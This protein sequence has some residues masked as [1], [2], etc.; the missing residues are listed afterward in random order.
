MQLRSIWN[1]FTPS[2][3]QMNTA[4]QAQNWN[5]QAKHDNPRKYKAA[6]NAA[7]EVNRSLGN[8]PSG[9][10]TDSNNRW[11]APLNAKQMALIKH[12][13]LENVNRPGINYNR[14]TKK[15]R[16]LEAILATPNVE[17]PSNNGLSLADR[18]EM[19]NRNIPVIT[20]ADLNYIGGQM[21]EFIGHGGMG[22][23]GGGF[24]GGK[25]AGRT[26]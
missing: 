19:I 9:D 20:N 6:Q 4:R 26:G 25:G 22:G 12:Y 15:Q 23:P 13:G 8:L 16:M 1:K 10:K 18:L 2:G 21:A 5:D 24:P 17:A 14:A 11:N 3:A 7:S